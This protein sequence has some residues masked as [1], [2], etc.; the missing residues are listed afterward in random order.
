MRKLIIAL[1][2][3][4]FLVFFCNYAN[5]QAPLRLEHLD[6]NASA[7]QANRH[8]QHKPQHKPHHKPHHRPDRFNHRDPW[9]WGI[10]WNNHWGPSVGIGWGNY[11]RWGSRWGWRDPWYYGNRYR[12][13]NSG[14]YDYPRRPAKVEPVAVQPVQRTTTSISYD[15]GIKSLPENARA[16]QQD[17]KIVYEWNGKVYRYDWATENYVVLDE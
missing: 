9:R 1:L 14:Y 4:S 8:L 2:S 6:A 7:S 17:G 11:S 15:T 13:R 16:F 10:G 3:A 12:Y 5:A